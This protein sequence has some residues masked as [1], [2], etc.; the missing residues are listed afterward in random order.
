MACLT[1][2]RPGWFVVGFRPGEGKITLP[3]EIELPDR[4]LTIG[5]KHHIRM[6]LNFFFEFFFS[7]FPLWRHRGGHPRF[8]AG[9]PVSEHL[10]NHSFGHDRP[11]RAKFDKKLYFYVFITFFKVLNPKHPFLGVFDPPKPRFLAFFGLYFYAS[12]YSFL[13]GHPKFTKLGRDIYFDFPK[14][15]PRWWRH[16]RPPLGVK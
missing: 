1:L 13:H 2:F 4:I 11:N 5:K 10:F 16:H 8:W 12:L 6:G 14:I 7:I 3:Y 9:G 15:F